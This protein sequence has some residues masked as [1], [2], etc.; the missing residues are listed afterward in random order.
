MSVLA[1]LMAQAV[2]AP[3]PPPTVE[4]LVEQE[5]VVTARRRSC[6]LSIAD[7][8]VGSREFRAR[9]VEWRAGTPVRVVVT[10]GADYRC[11]AKIAFR[12]RDYGVTRIIFDSGR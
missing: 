1:L 4:P 5:V 6:Q 9:A 11:L 8:V 2:P 12:L 3:A 10:D 7:R